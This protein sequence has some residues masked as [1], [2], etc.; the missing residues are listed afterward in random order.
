MNEDVL[1]FE[2]SMA[3]KNT[4]KNERTKHNLDRGLGRRHKRIKIKLKINEII[5]QKDEGEKREEAKN[6]NGNDD[7]GIRVRSER[8]FRNKGNRRQLLNKYY[9]N[10]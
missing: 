6:E 10:L 9:N 1:N 5:P 8:I 3:T 2:D 4:K 7:H